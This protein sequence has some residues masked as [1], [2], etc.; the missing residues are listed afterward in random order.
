MKRFDSFITEHIG[1]KHKKNLLL[2]MS[3]RHHSD[4]MRSPEGTVEMEK[5]ITYT[6]SQ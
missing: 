1:H 5:S 6:T 4:G 2:R 3:G